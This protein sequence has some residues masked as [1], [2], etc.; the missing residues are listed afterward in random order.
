MRYKIK[1]PVEQRKWTPVPGMP[2]LYTAPA[3]R[4]VRVKHKKIA[5]RDLCTSTMQYLIEGCLKCRHIFCHNQCKD[6]HP[7][8][9]DIPK[10]RVARH[11]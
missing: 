4:S 1:D 11:P 2:G 9:P 7:C 6:P 3:I 8:R 10:G 5:A